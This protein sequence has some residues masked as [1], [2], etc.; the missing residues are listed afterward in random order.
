MTRTKSFIEQQYELK[1]V[2]T[3]DLK[4]KRAKTSDGNELDA[5]SKKIEKELE[6]FSQ[7]SKDSNEKDQRQL[8]QSVQKRRASVKFSRVE[9]NGLD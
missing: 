1:S 3:A 5:F 2:K 7:S 6:V 8:R 4:K 9:A